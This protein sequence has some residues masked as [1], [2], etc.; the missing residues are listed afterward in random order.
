MSFPLIKQTNGR[1][2]IFPSLF[3][4][5]IGIFGAFLFFLAFFGSFWNFSGTGT[6]NKWENCKNENENGNERLKG[7]ERA[8]GHNPF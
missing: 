2:L 6:E 8:V 1:T 7:R 3:P 4:P 5:E